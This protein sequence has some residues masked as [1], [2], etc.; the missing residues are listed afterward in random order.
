MN[1][2][3][4]LLNSLPPLRRRK[5]S[6]DLREGLSDSAL[7][8][9]SSNTYLT[10]NQRGKMPEGGSNEHAFSGGEQGNTTEIMQ[11]NAMLIGSDNQAQK[12]NLKART[13]LGY[14]KDDESNAEKST[15][16][17]VTPP[18]AA[19][20]KK[21]LSKIFR[22]KGSKKP[23]TP[24]SS[25]KPSGRKVISAPILVDAS[26]NAKAL[27]SS[28][29]SLIDVSPSAKH[30]VNYSRP[31]VRHSSNDGSSGS[32]IMRQPSENELH[33]S[34]PFVGPGTVSRG[35]ANDINASL[36]SPTHDGQLPGTNEVQILDH[37]NSSTVQ[38]SR[39]ADTH[40]ALSG[41]LST[42]NNA[43]GSDS[44]S[45]NP[46]D[47]SGDED[48]VQQAV[49]VPIVFSGRAKLVDIR[50]PHGTKA[51]APR[52]QFTIGNARTSRTTQ[53]TDH[54]AEVLGAQ[55]AAR[56]YNN[57]M[58]SQSRPRDHYTEDPFIDPPFRPLL[59]KP[60]NEIAA[61]EMARLK[62][63]REGGNPAGGD[64]TTARGRLEGC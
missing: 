44:D 9:M 35:L 62:A 61:R 43:D 28:A 46:S 17:L 4:D 38:G 12:P 54:D 6:E 53:L 5:G 26:P 10:S 55:D 58:R 34:N 1:R 45:F 63:S 13:L 18:K 33:G 60:A 23:A 25:E 51:T 16:Y 56:Y 8:I 48:S 64:T 24:S 50:P 40:H 29:S 57:G 39:A 42:A 15:T 27:L 36:V 41:T 22:R 7:K 11:N 3:S 19:H 2:L 59:A 37:S 20:K 14:V 52:N 21:P 32:P 31:I 30:V 47:Y 49:P